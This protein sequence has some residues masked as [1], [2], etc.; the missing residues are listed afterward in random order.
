MNDNSYEEPNDQLNSLSR[1]VES[2]LILS[3][4]LKLRPILEYILD[5]ACTL[6]GAAAA[7][8]MLIDRNTHD[9]VFEASTN[10]PIEALEK[11]TVPMENSIAGTIVRED[12]PILIN[13]ISEEPRHYSLVG[14]KVNLEIQSLLG[15]PMRYRDRVVGVL[16]TLNKIDGDWSAQDRNHLLILASQAAVAVENARLVEELQN[17]LEEVR[18]LDKLKSDFIAIASHEL[19]TP[20]GVILGY[21]SFLREEAKGELGDHAQVV[22]NSALHLRNLIED[23]TSMRNLQ[24]GR[25]ELQISDVSLND[26]LESVKW[27]VASLASVKQQKLEVRLPHPN[28]VLDADP[29][30]LGMALTNIVNNAIKFTP[31]GGSIAIWSETHGDEVWLRVQDDGPGLPPGQDERIFLQFYQV[32][33]HMTRRHGGM[34]LGLSIAK[35]ISEAHRGRI[36]AESPGIDQ[37]S[38][39]TIALP[40]TLKRDA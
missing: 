14:E 6:T 18:Q 22:L 12:R 30:R 27:D 32:E 5:T 4:M 16:E 11:I 31:E 13:D 23:M 34:G 15:V 39:F 29:A 7:S 10:T 2:S 25:R 35:A 20:L 36:W 3:S 37:G 24:V 28:I 17:A 1:L 19:R 38:T 33:D 26:L 40:L 21:A 9:L 8:V